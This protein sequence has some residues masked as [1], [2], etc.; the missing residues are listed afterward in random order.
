MTINPETEIVATSHDPIARTHSYTI[1]RNGKRWTVAIPDAD[2]QQFGPVKGADAA[3]NHASRRKHLAM[4]LEAA[5]G[6][7]PD[8]GEVRRITYEP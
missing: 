7:A 2:F 1:E 5:M 8:H 6:G 3:M 4:R